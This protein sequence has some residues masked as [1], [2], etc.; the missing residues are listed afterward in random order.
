MPPAANFIASG[1]GSADAPTGRRTRTRY[2]DRVGIVSILDVPN[3]RELRR[4]TQ[5][6][7]DNNQTLPAIGVARRR[8][9]S[10]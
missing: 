7:H 9:R 4:L 3:E 2:Q 8:S 5:Q 6:V 1:C 10:T